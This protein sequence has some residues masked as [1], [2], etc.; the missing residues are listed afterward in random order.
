MFLRFNGVGTHNQPWNC[1][2][3]DPCY[4][5]TDNETS[6]CCFHE[7]KRE[8]EGGENVGEHCYEVNASNEILLFLM[9]NV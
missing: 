2:T 4:L 1:I 9:S 7:K 6:T 5:N 3:T 8:R